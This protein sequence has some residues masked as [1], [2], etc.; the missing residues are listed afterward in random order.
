MYVHAPHNTL[1]KSARGK[2]KRHRGSTDS[3][4]SVPPSKITVGLSD[5]EFSQ[6]KSVKEDVETP[7]EPAATLSVPYSVTSSEI[8]DRAPRE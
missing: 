5:C 7:T 2:N 1:P 8:P 6:E 3:V 4:E